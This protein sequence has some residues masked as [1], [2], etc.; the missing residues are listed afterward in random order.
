MLRR[1]WIVLRNNEGHNSRPFAPGLGKGAVIY[2]CH[3]LTLGLEE[4]LSVD[5]SLQ[6]DLIGFNLFDDY[7]D[8]RNMGQLYASRIVNKLTC[9]SERKIGLCLTH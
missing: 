2:F 5:S 6:M 9:Q 1:W 3:F 8:S 7:D 4:S